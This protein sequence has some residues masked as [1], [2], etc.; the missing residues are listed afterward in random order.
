MVSVKDEAAVEVKARE[1]HDRDCRFAGDEK[2]PMRWEEL[3]HNDVAIWKQKARA[4]F[5]AVEAE[6]RWVRDQYL[7]ICE[8]VDPESEPMETWRAL[9][10]AVLARHGRGKA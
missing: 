7:K 4:E 8:T 3:A 9:A 2:C 6:A 10:R 5:E 1:M